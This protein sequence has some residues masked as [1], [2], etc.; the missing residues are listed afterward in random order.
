MPRTETITKTYYKF[1]ELSEQAQAKAVEKEQQ[2][3]GETW[4]EY[5]LDHDCFHAAGKIL[6]IDIDNIYFRGFWSQGDGACF[7]GSYQYKADMPKNIRE[8]FP[9]ATDLHEIADTLEAAQ[10]VLGDTSSSNVYA[11]DRYMHTRVGVEAANMWEEDLEDCGVDPAQA[12][13][14][15]DSVRQALQVFAHWIYTSLE[16]DYE[17]ATSE[18]NVRERLEDY[19]EIYEYDE[20]GNQI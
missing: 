7:E 13:D 20:D 18:E 3:Q 12:Y 9:T 14:A 17:Y 19:E 4:G 2:H 5:A 16:K 1:S 10:G 8:A 6:G 15:A 11:E